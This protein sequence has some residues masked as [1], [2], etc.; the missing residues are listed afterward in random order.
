MPNKKDLPKELYIQRQSKL[1]SH[2]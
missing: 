2:N 1:Q